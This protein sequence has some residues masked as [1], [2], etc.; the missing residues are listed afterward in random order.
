MEKNINIID[1]MDRILELPEFILHHIL[2][3]LKSPV[4]LVRCSALSKKWFTLTASFPVLN[5]NLD[6][7][8]KSVRASKSSHRIHFGAGREM[9]Y[10][11]IA[12]TTS[13]FY[14]QN[15][16]VHTFN[17]DTRLRESTEVDIIERCLGLV[18]MKRIKVLGIKAYADTCRVPT[19]KCRLPNLLLSASSL[20]SLTVSDCELPSW[21]MVNVVKFKSLKLLHLWEVPLDEEI[22][23]C[24]NASFLLLEELNVEY[25]PGLK[26][27]C[28]YWLQKLQKVSVH[29]VNG[30]ERVDIGA[31]NLRECQILFFNG[32]GRGAPPSLN[33]ASYKQLAT[34]RL[35]K[36]P[37]PT[38]KGFTDFLS[39]FP[40]LENLFLIIPNPCNSLSHADPYERD[41][42]ESKSRMNCCHGN[43]VDT[44]CDCELPSWSMVDV[45]KFKS[46]KLLHLWEVPLDEEIIKCLNASFLI[47]EELNVEY[48]PGLKILCIY[49]LQKLQKVSVHH[50]NGLE[51]VDIG[52]LNLREC[53]IL[54]FNGRGRDFSSIDFEQQSHIVKFTYEKLLQQEDQGEINI[55]LVLSYSSK[56]KMN[57]SDL[58]SLL[59]AL[60]HEK[61]CK[62]ITFVKEKGSSAPYFNGMHALCG[63]HKG[64]EYVFI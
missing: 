43:D 57:F 56:V 41:A 10:E 45:V 40:L 32:R 60:P 26:I 25:G 6:E 29:H 12:Y 16:S 38:S 52:A 55:Q 54:F 31:L 50:V 44:L 14:E 11:Y 42:P 64:S 21:S 47:L 30:L 13:K 58:N 2:S 61:P 17:L 5:F 39:N 20:T 36:N 28:I 9:F 35:N 27:L 37:F 19:P 8:T 48:G 46:L 59:T 18:L 4:D 53:Q 23:K 24:L 22:I 62:T 51:R 33:L 15:V 1:T 63:N 3:L 34:L 7:F 49:R